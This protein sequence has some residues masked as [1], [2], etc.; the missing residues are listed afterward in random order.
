MDQKTWLWRKRSSEKI[1]VASDKAEL[2]QKSNKE[3]V[4][5]SEKEVALESSVKY[6]NEKSASVI[7]G[8]NAED[9]LVADHA[10]TAQEAIAGAKF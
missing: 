9:D 8:C 6:L 3:E 1:I 7:C 5:P 2:T 4:L 10:K